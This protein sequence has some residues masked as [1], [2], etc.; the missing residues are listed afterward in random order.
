MKFPPL[1][2]PGVNTLYCLEEWRGVQRISPPGD[3]FTPG[4]QS[5]PSMGEVKNGPL[6]II[7]GTLGYLIQYCPF[8]QSHSGDHPRG[9]IQLPRKGWAAPSEEAPRQL[10][11]R[12]IRHKGHVDDFR[13]EQVGNLN[14]SVVKIYSETN[15]VARFLSKKIIFPYWKKHSSSLRPAF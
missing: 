13:A 11:N 5:L 6:G 10:A 7:I 4:G 9:F 14:A 1:L 3:E 15:C 8:L 2:P 12:Q